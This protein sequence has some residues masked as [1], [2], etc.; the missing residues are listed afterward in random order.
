MKGFV[1]KIIITFIDN[2]SSL[3]TFKD[4]FENLKKVRFAIINS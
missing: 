3:I 4:K 2:I 1:E